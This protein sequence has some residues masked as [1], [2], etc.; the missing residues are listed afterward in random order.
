MGADLKVVQNV[1]CVGSRLANARSHAEGGDA[2]QNALP[3]LRD[4]A[5]VQGEK[6]DCHHTHTA[7]TAPK[8]PHG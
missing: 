5:D 8:W 4:A 6:Y 7:D 2:L 3:L 1:K